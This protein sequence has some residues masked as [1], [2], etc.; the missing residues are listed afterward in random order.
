LERQGRVTADA[1]N[2]TKRQRVPEHDV[3]ERLRHRAQEPAIAGVNFDRLTQ[4]RQP[5]WTGM[6]A[7]VPAVRQD[8]I[9]VALSWQGKKFEQLS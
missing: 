7:E 9:Q 2:F 1:R 3:A 5:N 6:T 8:N 4:K